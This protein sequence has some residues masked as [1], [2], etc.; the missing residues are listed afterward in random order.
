MIE[1]MVTVAILAVLAAIAIPMYTDFAARARRA[2]AV[3]ALEGLAQLQEKFRAN[4]AWYATAITAD[5]ANVSCTSSNKTLLRQQGTTSDDGYYTLAI[6]DG[7]ATATTFT[8]TATPVSGGAQDG[9]ACG[10]FAINQNGPITND[11]SYAGEQCWR[12]R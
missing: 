2:D 9:D 6:V 1:L 7:S 10:T 8:A 11:N 3:T 4:C 12:G 5:T